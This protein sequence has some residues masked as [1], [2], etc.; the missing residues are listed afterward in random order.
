MI[1]R[2]L[3]TDGGSV[4]KVAKSKEPADKKTE[5]PKLLSVNIMAT[6][7]VHPSI[8]PSGQ[9]SFIYI[10]LNDKSRLVIPDNFNPHSYIS[11]SLRGPA[12]D[13]IFSGNTQVYI[14][15]GSV[16]MRNS[17]DGLSAKVQGLMGKNP[18]TGDLFVFSNRYHNMIKVLY[19]HT[20]GFCLWMKR[21]EKGRFK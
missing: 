3:F 9:E 12:E 20:N 18:F 15:T 14:Y 13:M 7:A 11:Q 4:S 5:E 17:I 10:Q 2:G 6:E 19:W 1:A 21:L 8:L 16:D